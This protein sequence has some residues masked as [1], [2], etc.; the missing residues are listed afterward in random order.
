MGQKNCLNL[1][2]V[3]IKTC[4]TIALAALMLMTSGL[5]SVWAKT[6]NTKKTDSKSA[7][8]AKKNKKNKKN[9]FSKKRNRKF[10]RVGNGPDLRALTTELPNNEYTEMPDNGV[11]AV[12]TK[13]GL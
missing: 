9:K 8:I 6:Q 13:T 4:A 3:M 1:G 11:N 2:L 12:E 7:K 5:D 10:K